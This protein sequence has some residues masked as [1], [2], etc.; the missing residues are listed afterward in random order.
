MF[1]SSKKG[2]IF[3]YKCCP[4]NPRK[5][6]CSI[7][8]ELLYSNYIGSCKCN[9]FDPIYSVCRCCY[10]MDRCI[11]NI[12]TIDPKIRY[13]IENIKNSLIPLTIQK[14]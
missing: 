14:I 3:A 6:Q 9:K 10:F 1:R 5:I 2:T 4:P 13:D 8:I 7:V 11:I 12:Y